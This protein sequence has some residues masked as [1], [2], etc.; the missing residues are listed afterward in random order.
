MAKVSISIP[1]T[2]LDQIEKNKGKH[3]SFSSF[4]R[5]LFEKGLK[6]HELE[7][8]VVSKILETNQ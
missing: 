4:C 8:E 5:T 6:L 7:L 2:L 3:E 1:D